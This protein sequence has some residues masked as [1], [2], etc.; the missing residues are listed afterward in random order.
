[1]GWLRNKLEQQRRR[2]QVEQVQ[3]EAD[4]LLRWLAQRSRWGPDKLPEDEVAEAFATWIEDNGIS[5]QALEYASGYVMPRQSDGG[6]L[7]SVDLSGLIDYG[8]SE[9]DWRRVEYLLWRVSP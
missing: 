3:Y 5:R 8:G 4:E 6:A 1:M 9:V 7:G 2:G